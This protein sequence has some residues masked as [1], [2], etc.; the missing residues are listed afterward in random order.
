MRLILVV[1]VL[2]LS[3]VPPIPTSTPAGAAN[4]QFVLGFKTI[5]DLIPA[6]VGDCKVDQHYNQQ[7]GD[8]LQE[9]FGGLLVWRKS[10]NFTAFTDGYRSW[11]NGP[12]GIQMR[13]NNERFEWEA[14]EPS[15]KIATPG[16]Y[17]TNQYPEADNRDCYLYNVQ[18]WS[19]GRTVRLRQRRIEPRDVGSRQ[20]QFMGCFSS[21]VPS[22][23]PSK[24]SNPPVA[25]NPVPQ[26]PSLPSLPSLAGQTF[27]ARVEEVYV[28]KVF[29]SSDKA[30]IVRRNGEVYLI[31]K[32]VG[33]LSLW[34]F[35]GKTVLVYSPGTFAGV[36]SRV[37]IPDRGQ[38]CRIWD[39]EYLDG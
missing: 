4:C 11:V 30:L 22:P 34:L 7:N 35:E 39:S 5:H 2:I 16:A 19:D 28:A 38:E 20:Q 24:P 18:V 9:A 23:T 15:A 29:D 12:F 26:L 17:I 27:G 32:G 14:S 3:A 33:C 8:A 25:A 21:A 6:I 10:D 13:L 37:L 31:E 1:A 36:G